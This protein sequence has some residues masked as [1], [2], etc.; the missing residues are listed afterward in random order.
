MGNEVERMSHGALTPGRTFHSIPLYAP[1]IRSFQ[2]LTLA[3]STHSPGAT[4]T[5][6]HSV[7]V[8]SIRPIRL[9]PFHSLITFAHFTPFTT[10]SLTV[11]ISFAQFSHSPTPGAYIPCARWGWTGRSLHSLNHSSPHFVHSVHLRSVPR[12]LST[13]QHFQESIR[14]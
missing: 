13:L 6:S 14:L 8:R 12:S 5:H 9:T 4:L 3:T 2:S 1:I 7:P 10:H 11:L